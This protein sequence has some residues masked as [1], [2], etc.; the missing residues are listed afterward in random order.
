MFK[1]YIDASIFLLFQI[2]GEQCS[3]IFFEA[4]RRSLILEG[5]S[6]VSCPW[7]MHIQGPSIFIDAS[8]TPKQTCFKIGNQ[9]HCKRH[10]SS[11]Q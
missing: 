1:E 10:S 4:H 2:E 3:R 8:K 6:K 11:S 7:V 5:G 9:A